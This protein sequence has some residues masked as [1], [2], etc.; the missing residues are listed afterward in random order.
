VLVELIGRD[1]LL[2]VEE[3]VAREDVGEGGGEEVHLPAGKDQHGDDLVKRVL[4]DRDH[5]LC[6]FY[7]EAVQVSPDAHLE[8]LFVLGMC[9]NG[10]IEVES[11]PSRAFITH[12][13]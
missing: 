10:C 12:L 1:D 8:A 6:L 13:H 7:V 5:L 4:K 11:A 2:Q 3:A 9:N